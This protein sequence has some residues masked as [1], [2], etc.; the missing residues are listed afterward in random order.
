M[1][2]AALKQRLFWWGWVLRWSWALQQCM[3]DKP[4]LSWTLVFSWTWRVLLC[5]DEDC[6]PVL[7]SGV[8]VRRSCGQ[9]CWV[10]IRSPVLPGSSSSFLLPTP[11]ESRQAL[12]LS[13]EKIKPWDPHACQE[14]GRLW[15]LA[16]LLTKC[17]CGNG[18]NP[19]EEELS[20]SC[21]DL[22]LSSGQ[23]P[24][25]QP[26]WMRLVKWDILALA[27]KPVQACFSPSQGPQPSCAFGGG[28]GVLGGSSE[29]TAGCWSNHSATTYRH[30][31]C[32]INIKWAILYLK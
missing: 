18:T 6:E 16:D 30:Y 32:V 23:Q 10:L 13:L 21:Y 22:F 24:C 3:E 15:E 26:F 9:L 2:K 14:A 25:A 11:N 8:P 1:K 17:S 5:S 19:R 29:D 28:S 7:G 20:Y 31:L 12:L 27:V 4:A